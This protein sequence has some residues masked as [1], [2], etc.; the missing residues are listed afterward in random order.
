MQRYE[1]PGKGKSLTSRSELSLVRFPLR[2]F[3]SGLLES[4]EITSDFPD[5]LFPTKAGALFFIIPYFDLKLD[6]QYGS[7]T[8]S[9]D[10]PTRVM[11]CLVMAATSSSAVQC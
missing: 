4:A 9:L 6:L 2:T 11:E 10:Q 1:F 5:E 7:S 3:N 8:A